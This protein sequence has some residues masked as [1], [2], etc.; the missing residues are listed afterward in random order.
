MTSHAGGAAPTKTSAGMLETMTES[1][2]SANKVRKDS[3]SGER[4]VLLRAA[5]LL[6]SFDADQPVLQLC[7]LVDRSQLPKSTVHRLAEQL[8]H[9]GWLERSPF[10]Y[11]VGVRLFEVGG[12]ADRYRV[13]RNRAIPHLQQLS[14]ATGLAVQLG[15]LDGSDVVYLERVLVRGFELPNRDGGR[16]PAYCTAL[17]KVLLAFGSAAEVDDIMQRKLSHLTPRTM[18]NPSDLFNELARVRSTGFARDHEEAFVGVSCLAVP[19]RGSGRAIAAIS[20]CGP[21]GRVSIEEHLIQLQR[22]A[23]AIW[24]DVFHKTDMDDRLMPA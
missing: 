17:G 12:L 10:G 2:R 13:L 14:A 21:P 9:L 24:A 1:E 4:S 11:R 22:V 19:L 7:E 18:A 3:D 8:V 5:H 16:M 23:G 15:V 6:N 20:A